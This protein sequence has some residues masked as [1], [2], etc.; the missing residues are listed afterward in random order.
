MKLSVLL[1]AV[2][3]LNAAAAELPRWVN[4]APLA[5]GTNAEAIAADQRWLFE[6]TPMD[7]VGYSCTLVPESRPAFDKAAVLA[8]RFREQKR[9]LAGA[10]GACGILF[11]ATMGHGWTPDSEAKFTR[12]VKG[13]G[14]VPYVFCP[15]DRDFLAYV[16]AQTATLVAERPDF[17]MVDDDTRMYAGRMGC[18]CRL[19]LEEFARRTGRTFTRETLQAGIATN[20]VLFA[21]WDALLRDSVAGLMKTVREEMDRVDPEMP[22]LFCCCAEDVHHAAHMAKTLAAPGQQ[23]VVR[24]NNGRYCCETSRDFAGWLRRTS[25]E[26]AV[27]KSEGC[28]VLDEPDTC[29]QNRYSMSAAD[30]LAH[31]TLAVLEG[32]DGG[33]F[34]ITRMNGDE[35]ASGL[36]YRG[37]LAENSAFLKTLVR[38]APKWEGV[39]IPLPRPPYTRRNVVNYTVNWGGNLFGRTGI[40][41]A[42]T[43][44]TR[45]VNAIGP[46]VV[47][48]SILTAAHLRELLS[49]RLLV[50]GATA[51]ALTAKGYAG[52]LGLSAAK[53]E[54]PSPSFERIE[55]GGTIGGLYNPVKFTAL[56]RGAKVR[57]DFRHRSAALAD[58]S[59]SVGPAA[60]DYANAAG[61]RVV[62][63]ASSFPPW[64]HHSWFGF[65]NETRKRQLVGLLK[66][67]HG[68]RLPFAYYPGDGEVMLRWGRAKDGTR[69][70][71]AF[72]SGH[73]DIADF[74]VVFP[75]APKRIRRLMPDGGWKDVAFRTGPDGVT[76]LGTEVRFLRAAVFAV[77]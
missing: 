42:Y 13:D 32:C 18:F 67:L 7:S 33:K 54:G 58:D 69:L 10:K 20:D 31:V 26:I 30:L 50:D 25:M 12:F 38:L 41:F 37:V 55:D 46:D 65:Y 76:V 6:H 3:V 63:V 71:A 15:L 34:W 47:D 75:E 24:L 77:D 62:S 73:D 56:A 5:T 66:D 23:P 36:A 74:P 43:P 19:H 14:S 22:G 39:G 52:D 72:A 57:S 68:G 40:P 9:L 8:K 61:G 21:A 2:F 64:L 60:V 44:E 48:R 28:L 29:P 11:Q 70:M 16:R 53:W 17:V 49:G 27:L 51:V 4:V 59:V 45:P 1:P 35:P